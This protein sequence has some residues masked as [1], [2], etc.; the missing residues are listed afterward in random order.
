MAEIQTRTDISLRRLLRV[1]MPDGTVEVVDLE[2]YLRG[3]V[4]HEIGAGS[5]SEALKAQAVAARCY[6]LTS[7]RHLDMGADICTTT[8]CQVWKPETDP[9]SDAA[10]ADTKAVVAL[11]NDR[12]INAFFFAHCTGHTKNIEDVWEAPAVAYLRGVTCPVTFP[13]LSGHGVGMCQ[14]GAI[15]FGKQGEPYTDILTHYY[16]DTEVVRGVFDEEV[17]EEQ[18]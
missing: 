13:E 17:S 2:E 1:L 11:H 4:P 12:V 15:A 16:S 5:P 7:R 9:R 8:H 14:E 10:I 18:P 3:V 6:A